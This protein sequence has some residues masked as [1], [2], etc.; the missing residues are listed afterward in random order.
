MQEKTI[1]ISNV[2]INY[3]KVG[4]GNNTILCFPGALGTIWSDFKSLITNIDK[5]KFTVVAFDPPGY[6]RSRP[7]N[8]NF[9]I[10]FYK[11]DA[12]CAHDL[13]K[14]LGCNKFSLLGWSD[15]GISSI[16]LAALYPD[17][18]DKLIIWGA[19]AYLLSE[20]IQACENI[21]DTKNWSPKAKKPLIK[22]YGEDELQ[23][24]WSSWC[25]TMS[26]IKNKKEGNICMEHLARIKCSTLILH[27]ALDPM[28]HSEHPKYLN[29]HIK[30]SRY[31]NF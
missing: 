20:D 14:T 16:I 17:A 22:L 1:S 8:R 5:E 21:R 26:E 25:D 29:T 4:A 23:N 10:D 3:L 27:G 6:G 19:N 24:M 12:K 7:P 13:M 9:N 31:F 28:I 15:G 30:N 11:N 18:V 2:T